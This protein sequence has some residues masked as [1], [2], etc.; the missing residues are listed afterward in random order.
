MS[1][2]VSVMKDSNGI[3]QRTQVLAIVL[4]V[5]Q[6]NTGSWETAMTAALVAL[7]VTDMDNAYNAPLKIL[8]PTVLMTGL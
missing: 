2:C 5:E 8:T 3:H 7:L 1:T 4:L 6:A